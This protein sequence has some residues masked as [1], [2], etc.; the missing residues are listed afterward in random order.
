MIFPV[1]S[2]DSGYSISSEDLLRLG[3]IMGMEQN[4]ILIDGASIT[5]RSL[6]L[7]FSLRDIGYLCLKNEN[8]E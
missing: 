4:A 5:G 3:I 6:N 1:K 2:S 8:L 7:I